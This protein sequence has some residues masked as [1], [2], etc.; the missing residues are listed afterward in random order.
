MLKAGLNVEKG[1]TAKS[2]LKNEYEFLSTL[3]VA[4]VSRIIFYAERND[5]CFLAVEW[6]EPFSQVAGSMDAGQLL[7]CWDRLFDSVDHLYQCGIV[8]TDIHE[9]NICFRGRAPVLCDFEEARVTAAGRSVWRFFGCCG[10][11]QLWQCGAVSV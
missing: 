6:L 5:F 10:K 1:F 4:W 3:Q 11:K 9:F 7:Q 8:H 2:S